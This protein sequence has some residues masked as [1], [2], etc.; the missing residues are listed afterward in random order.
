M[1]FLDSR[2]S[3]VSPAQ[4]RAIDAEVRRQVAVAVALAKRKAEAAVAA[5]L[6]E[7][8]KEKAELVKQVDELVRKARPDGGTKG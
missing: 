8:E 6:E 7:A 5:A 2:R 1:G 3:K 4:Q